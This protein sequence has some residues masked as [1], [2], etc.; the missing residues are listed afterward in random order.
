MKKAEAD[1]RLQNIEMPFDG[2][3]MILGGFDVILEA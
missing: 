3:R 2:Q 1:K